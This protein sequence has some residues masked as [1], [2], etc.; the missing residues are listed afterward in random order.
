MFE[1]VPAVPKTS[2][3]TKVA[4]NREEMYYLL[5][6]STLE[7]LSKLSTNKYASNSLKTG[8]DRLKRSSVDYS[9]CSGGIEQN[10]Y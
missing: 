2:C 8:M 1:G 5:C 3:N 7:E 6:Y 10:S 4:K 9:C